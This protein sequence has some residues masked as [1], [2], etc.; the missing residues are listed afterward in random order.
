MLK[1]NKKVI[2]RISRV[3]G[4]HLE[5]DCDA[6]Q[7]V[8][9]TVLH[10]YYFV[11]PG[12]ATQK[13]VKKLAKNTVKGIEEGT[14]LSNDTG[15]DITSC[16]VARLIPRIVKLC[17]KFFDARWFECQISAIDED[18]FDDTL[19]NRYVER[20][21]AEQTSHIF[22]LIVHHGYKQNFYMSEDGYRELW[23][24]LNSECKK[25]DSTLPEI[26]GD[27]TDFPMFIF[28]CLDKTTISKILL[29]HITKDKDLAR[30]VARMLYYTEPIDA[31]EYQ[32]IA[33][34]YIDLLG[35][36]AFD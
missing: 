30:Y 22:Q 1:N 6:I 13:F 21:D 32:S 8:F 33:M 9:S 20:Y 4:K 24:E 34:S 35:F 3:C 10:A 27:Y 23:A 2:E 14:K 15:Y 19:L 17:E 31:V 16:A 11:K 29:K 7:A 25:I 5:Y 36:R 18:V 28:D 26:N 12:E